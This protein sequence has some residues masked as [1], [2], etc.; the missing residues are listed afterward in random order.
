MYDDHGSRKE[1]GKE[2]SCH[3]YK[4]FAVL[5]R[6]GAPQTYMY[7]RLSELHHHVAFI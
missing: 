2:W 1:A 7:V 4:A 6:S 3:S 5:A